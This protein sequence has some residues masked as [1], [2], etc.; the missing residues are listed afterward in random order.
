MEHSI[1]EV[2]DHHKRANDVIVVAELSEIDSSCDH[3]FKELRDQLEKRKNEHD[4]EI[5]LSEST[6]QDGLEEE[7]D[8]DSMHEGRKSDSFSYFEPLLLNVCLD[9]G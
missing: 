8:E 5:R 2:V 6:D 1:C 3:E 7:G 4:V 9:E